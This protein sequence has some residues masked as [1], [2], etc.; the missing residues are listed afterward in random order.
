MSSFLYKKGLYCNLISNIKQKA[1][2]KEYAVLKN[3]YSFKN[4][5]YSVNGNYN[6]VTIANVSGNK[7]IDTNFKNK[8][9]FLPTDIQKHQLLKENDILISLTGNVGRVS[10]N[11]GENNLLNQRVGLLIPKENINHSFLYYI[12]STKD[13]ESNMINSGQGAAQLNISINDI[14][15]YKIPITEINNQKEIVTILDLFYNKLFLE[16]TTLLKYIELKKGLMQ[17]MFV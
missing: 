10:L 16:E 3:G 7:Y 14:Y 5:E 8:Y 15:N 2:L 11:K 9:L 12:L 13:F 1:S 6:I 17:S 4:D